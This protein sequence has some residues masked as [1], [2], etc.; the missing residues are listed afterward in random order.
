MEGYEENILEGIWSGQ[1]EFEKS[2]AYS[3]IIEKRYD[4]EA[5]LMNY[6]SQG[7]LQACIEL[8]RSGNIDYQQGN[9]DDIYN[10]YSGDALRSYKNAMI[11]LNTLCRVSARKGGVTSF[12]VNCIS[13][14]YA[15]TIEQAPT[16][17]FLHTKLEPMMIS[18][19]CMLVQA[20]SV[21]QYS[22]ITRKIAAYI[23]DNLP[24]QITVNLLAEKFFLDPSALS[25]KFKHETG[26]SITEYINRHRITLAQYYLEE[27][28]RNITEVSFLVGYRDSNYFCRVFK[29]ITLITPTQY[30]KH[31]KSKGIF[32]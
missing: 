5:L 31:T 18:D 25:R 8:Q 11:V 4:G 22:S 26:V 16:A 12:M 23:V 27:R 14:K 2:G 13:H 24:S 3:R 28:Y 10:R 32:I 20:Y 17:E 21:N 1:T 6:I 9:L 29:K 7:N 19:Y 15:L 30:I